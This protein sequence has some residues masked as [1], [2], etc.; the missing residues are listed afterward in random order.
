LKKLLSELDGFFAHRR[1]YFVPVRLSPNALSTTPPHVG[2]TTHPLNMA[3][4]A[5]LVPLAWFGLEF[6]SAILFSE[7]LARRVP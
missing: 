4:S 6:L 7:A 2:F 1:R 3:I 5:L